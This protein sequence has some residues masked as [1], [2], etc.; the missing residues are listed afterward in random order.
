MLLYG[1]EIPP[2]AP[3]KYAAP[4]QLWK[5]RWK[6]DLPEIPCP[7]H[8]IGVSRFLD[9]RGDGVYSR[10]DSKSRGP[11]HRGKDEYDRRNFLV[12]FGGRGSA[13]C[14]QNDQEYHREYS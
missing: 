9:V 3:G 5:Y 8:S 13:S 6:N 14:S 4:D 10:D 7:V 2:T 1:Y 11:S 12:E